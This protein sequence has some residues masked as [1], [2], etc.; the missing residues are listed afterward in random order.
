MES[1]QHLLNAMAHCLKGIL[2]SEAWLES[3]HKEL[4]L[5]CI[6][7]WEKMRREWS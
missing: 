2:N 4:A 6:A 3:L 5:E 7:K 1:Q